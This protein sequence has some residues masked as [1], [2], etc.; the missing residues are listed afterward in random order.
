MKVSR[1]AG[2]DAVQSA[3]AGPLPG[4]PPEAAARTGALPQPAGGPHCSLQ[5]SP[6]ANTHGQARQTPALHERI[7]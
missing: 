7:F 5:G 3:A 1:A 2:G 4:R 6:A